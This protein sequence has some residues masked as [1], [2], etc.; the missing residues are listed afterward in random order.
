STMHPIVIYVLPACIAVYLLLFTLLRVTQNRNE[1]PAIALSIPFLEPV[2]GF[3]TRKVNYLHELKNQCQMPIF[4]LRMPFLRQYVITSPALIHAAQ[5][6]ANALN[7][8]PVARDFGF[9]FSGLLKSSQETLIKAYAAEGNGFTNIIHENLKPGDYLGSVSKDA[10]IAL[11]STLPS[12]LDAPKGH[13]DLYDSIRRPL[14]LALTD[15]LYG[16]HNPF[17][18]PQVEADWCAFL[19]GIKALLFALLPNI[20]ARK[21]M[22][23]RTRVTEAF[24]RYFE[25]GEY[26]QASPLIHKMF[27]KNKAYGLNLYEVSKMEIATALAVLSSGSISAFWLTFHIFSDSTILAAIRQEIMDKL[28]T[29]SEDG[30][31]R[32]DV[33]L[34][35][36][37]CP[38]LYST[39]QEMFRYHSSVISAK[40]VI[41]DTVLDGYHLKKDAVLMIPGPVVHKD[42][43]VWGPSAHEFDYLRFTDA[44]RDVVVKPKNIGTS[45][46]RPFGAGST[47]CPG[48]FFST[49]VILTYAAMSVLQFDIKPVNGVWTMSTKK[50]ADL[51]NAMPKP[52]FDVPVIITPRIDEK[53]GPLEFVW[54][55]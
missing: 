40:Q 16:P 29:V 19:P 52:D 10:L 8:G 3:M 50:K 30:T 31:R 9:L 4:T 39:F 46:F 49:N 11:K 38:I 23:A 1:P 41:N 33:S 7:F 28:V 54:G 17:R 22:Q 13:T 21:A 43:A 27:L 44:R 47:M 12:M 15:A 2:W 35:R 18:D 14:T 37:E 53:S 26:G 55:D 34:I 51:W 5:R 36:T 24:M 42:H 45:V 20:T 25:N 32:V 48:R 6:Q